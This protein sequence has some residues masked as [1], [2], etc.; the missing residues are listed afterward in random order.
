MVFQDNGIGLKEEEVYCFFIVIGESL[1]RDIFDVDDFIGWFG[2]GL[3]FCFVVINEIRV[4][5]WLVM[6]GNF[7]CWCGKVDGIY[8]I[9]F[10][11]EE[12]EIGLRVVLRF[13]NEWVYLF[14]YEVFKK[15]LVNYG[16]VLLYF[17]YLYGGEEEELVNI[18]L[19]VWFDLKVIWKELLDYGIK[20]F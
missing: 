8:Q 9:I 13:K 16:E 4:E 19:F 6:G 1:K 11:D 20:V 12:W 7:V 3:L 14:E 2:I 10:F 15:I 5:S 17:V 18:L